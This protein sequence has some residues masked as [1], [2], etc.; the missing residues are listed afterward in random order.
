MH[1][2]LG[3]QASSLGFQALYSAG[4]NP[5]GGAAPTRMQEGHAASWGHEIDRHTVGDRH[6]EQDSGCG[7]NP[8]VDSIDLDPAAARIEAHELDPVHLVA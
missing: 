6:R 4:E 8:A 5:A 2:N 3:F 7:G 1:Y